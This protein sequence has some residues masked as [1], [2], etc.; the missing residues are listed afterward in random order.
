MHRGQRPRNLRDIS[1]LYLSS[2]RE[3]GEAAADPGA[4]VMIAS[5]QGGPLRAWLSAGLAAAFGSQNT[6]ESQKAAVTLLET[7]PGLPSAGYYFALEPG[8]YLRPAIE[9]GAV[10]EANAG[11]SVEVICA[12][13]PVLLR[14]SD[15]GRVPGPRVFLF[16]FDWPGSA[17][18]AGLRGMLDS[19]PALREAGG[20]EGLPAFL[21][22]LSE[23][24]PGSAEGIL[25]EFEALFPG[26]PAL[27]LFPGEKV[28]ETAQGIEPCPFPPEMLEGLARRKP[29]AS[30]FLSGLA[31]EIFQRLGSRKRGAGSDGS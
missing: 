4:L 17:G 14:Q 18:S 24:Y 27:A 11:R 29:P 10:V 1:H 13:D 31:G 23:R 7:G 5:L 3:P 26:G 22:T 21:L 15:T 20:W 16:A 30:S 19:I 8:C 9:P 6:S 2:S 28:I 12:R 25:R